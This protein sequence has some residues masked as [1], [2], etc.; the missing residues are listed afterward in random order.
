MTRGRIPIITDY[1]KTDLV[2]LKVDPYGGDP[3]SQAT[4]VS[5]FFGK[6]R[7]TITV[8]ASNTSNVAGRADYE[9]DGTDDHLTIQEAIDALPA[10]G[11]RVL[12][13]D[14]AFT[15]G[16]Q[17]VIPHD[18]TLTGVGKST[19]INLDFVQDIGIVNKAADGW[20]ITVANMRID[21]KNKTNDLIEFQG[22]IRCVFH[23]LELFNG[24]HDGIELAVN[25]RDCI[26]HNVHAYSSGTYHGIEI[27]D[28]S[29][30]NTISNCVVY[31]APASGIVI[32]GTAHHNLITG[33]IS[34]DNTGYG[35]RLN[36]NTHDN[37]VVGNLTEGNTVG[38]V[39]D[40]G[41]DNTVIAYAD[42][43]VGVGA[44]APAGK[45]HIDQSVADAA[46]P[47]LVLDQADVSEGF[48]NFVGSDR[49]VIGEGTN[50][51]VSVRV[52]LGGVVYRLA[53]Y[54]D[55]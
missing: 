32:D 38:H 33:C 9:C 55:A 50:S 26:I 49:G 24:V 34:R 11:G 13:L 10:D 3:S 53:L 27:D 37:V 25:S 48:I 20:R 17:I 16:G 21:G 41:T 51:T 8:A 44:A 6:S 29:Y 31:G 23:N 14:G 52:E 36:A 1:A 12:L 47:A 45:Y 5:N 28:G 30:N 43:N 7:P 35:I 54:A 19:L 40:G 4:P 39:L 22:G 18:T 15:C 42:G 46:I 2:H